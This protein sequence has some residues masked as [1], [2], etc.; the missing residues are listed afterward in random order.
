MTQQNH[1]THTKK[2]AEVDHGGHGVTALPLCT[3]IFA[4][5]NETGHSFVR[6]FAARLALARASNMDSCSEDSGF[7]LRTSGFSHEA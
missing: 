5:L 2:H 4:L 7:G 6:S 1:P 3:L